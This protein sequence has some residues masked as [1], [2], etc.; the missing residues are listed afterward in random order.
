MS[1]EKRKKLWLMA[2]GLSA[3]LINGLLGTGGGIAAVTLLGRTG[4]SK[5]ECH[6][7][8]IGVILPLSLCSA[9][10]YLYRGRFTL[11]QALPYLP[12]GLVGAAAGAL[13]LRRIPKRWLRLLFG[14][15]AVYSACRL[16][17]R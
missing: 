15:V 9:A 16:F 13:L 11:G 8:S 5:K 6:A 2:T 4:L 14:G 17:L 3:G 12:A 7:T 10:V 1:E